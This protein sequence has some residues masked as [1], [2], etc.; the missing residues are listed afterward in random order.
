MNFYIDNAKASLVSIVR[1]VMTFR[2]VIPDDFSQSAT[3]T[4]LTEFAYKTRPSPLL[5]D[6]PPSL[7]YP[8]SPINNIGSMS[9]KVDSVATQEDSGDSLGEEVKEVLSVEAYVIVGDTML[10]VIVSHQCATCGKSFPP[11]E[12]LRPWVCQHLEEDYDM[13][14]SMLFIPIHL[15]PTNEP[16]GFGYRQ[17]G[18]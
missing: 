9:A 15:L 3:L 10:R 14:H 8:F 1:C 18:G 4:W 7:F 16:R 13:H 2:F 17:S 5:F 6:V 11:M 12:E